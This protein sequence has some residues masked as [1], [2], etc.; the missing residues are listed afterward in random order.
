MNFDAILGA[1]TDL[2]YLYL[3]GLKPYYIFYFSYKKSFL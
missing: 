2:C 3:H 1:Y